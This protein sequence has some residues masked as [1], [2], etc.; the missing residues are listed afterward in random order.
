[1][2]VKRLRLWLS[3]NAHTKKRDDD[4]V[5]EGFL[6]RLILIH[7]T[8]E[9]YCCIYGSVEINCKLR[10]EVSMGKYES[11]YRNIPVWSDSDTIVVGICL[12]YELFPRV[13]YV[14]E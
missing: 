4:D 6:L 8:P 9:Y 1:M 5:D 12:I 10:N 7:N 3:M 11:C 2:F 13:L 14:C